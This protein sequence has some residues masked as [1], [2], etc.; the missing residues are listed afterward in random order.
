MV[1]MAP[2]PPPS[3]LRP[4][5]DLDADLVSI[6]AD[7]CAIN[8]YASCRAVCVP[9][10]AA[11]P[12]PLS[13]PFAFLP[14][15]DAATGSPDPVSLGACSL[16]A[17]CWYRL[18]G[19]RQ[20]TRLSAASCRCVG[21][22][23]GWVALVAGGAGATAG[24]AG[25]L[26][27]NPVTGEEIPL[28]ASL[29]EPGHEPAPKIVFSPNPTPRDFAAASLCRPYRVAV[30]R[31]FDGH[32]L[33]LVVGTHGLM[34]GAHL[35]DAAYDDDE[36]KVYCLARDGGVYV[37]RLN[38]RRRGSFLAVEVRPLLR[39]PRGAADADAFPA[40]YDAISRLTDAKN[41]VLCGGG[42]ALYQVW[43]R[44]S[45]AG[46]ATVT[47]PTPDARRQRPLR[48][49]EGDVFVMRYDPSERLP[50][51]TPA[52]DLDGGAVL[53]GMNDAAVVRGEGVRADSVYYWDGPRDGAGGHEAVVF[54]V[55]TRAS[56][57]WPAAAAGG[58][59]SPVWYLLPPGGG[60]ETADVE[61]AAPEDGTC[62]E[63][64]C[65]D[66]EEEQELTTSY[67]PRGKYKIVPG[68]LD[69]IVNEFEACGLWRRQ[70]YMDGY[71]K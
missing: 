5:A 29:Y 68:R 17:G 24:F 10:R 61:A 69:P 62:R 19:L 23:D 18:H 51:W 22:R 60:V 45:G 12:P 34:D 48:V 35:V 4:W 27:F 54:D 64:E 40:P 46:S 67:R 33:T 37:L 53:V 2:P 20:P 41:L 25:P 11:L 49:A 3:P 8:D 9:W 1:D 32:S 36:D 47:P 30:Q 42:G 52:K 57:R 70:N 14:A 39:Q 15:S 31:V 50:R 59:S 58:A 65:C 71:S 55:A 16:H 13:R 63:H 26:L 28:D 7:C 66:E 43:R 21:A 56:V 38:R 6:I 44:P